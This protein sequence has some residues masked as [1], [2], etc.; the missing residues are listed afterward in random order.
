MR[1]TNIKINKIPRTQRQHLRAANHHGKCPYSANAKVLRGLALV[2][3]AA[4]E[5]ENSAPGNDGSHRAAA[6]NAATHTLTPAPSG[7]QD[8]SF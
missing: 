2:R 1:L 6:E 7:K 3:G 8:P 4:S 5:W